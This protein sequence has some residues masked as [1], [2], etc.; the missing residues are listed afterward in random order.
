MQPI[1]ML[2]NFIYGIWFQPI[3]LSQTLVLSIYFQFYVGISGE[4]GLLCEHSPS[5]G[6]VAM[7][8]GDHSIDCV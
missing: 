7:K 6:L 5:D 2:N 4:N 1:K 8:I 3:V